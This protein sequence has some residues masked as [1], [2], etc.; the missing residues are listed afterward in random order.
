MF[1]YLV[2]IAAIASILASLAYIRSMF[3]SNTKPNRV[4]WLM[5]SVAPL[6][7]AA[8]AVS[9][10][11]GWAVLP[12]FMSGFSPLI[13][14]TAS[15]F[16]KKAYWKLSKSDYLCGAMSVSAFVLWYLTKEPNIA[17]VFAMVSDA[18][19][20]V[21]T[22]MKAW[23]HPETESPWPYIVGVFSASTSF[24]A[25]V[26]WS[27]SELVFPIYLMAINVL[28]VLS[29]YN[30]RLSTFFC[31]IFKEYARGRTSAAKTTKP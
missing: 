6:T 5:W 31:G 10:G 29:V 24:A 12:V 27:F 18:F 15:F 19:A 2:F 28:L 21:P 23:S 8:A 20:A 30:K 13:I 3:R 17:I 1:E 7:A 11:V 22:L 16:T 4:T 9:E 25:A 26:A 14:F